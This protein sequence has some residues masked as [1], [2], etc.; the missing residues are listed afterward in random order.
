M[1]RM[2]NGGGVSKIQQQRSIEVV[3]AVLQAP[4]KNK[5]CFLAERSIHSF[6]LLAVSPFHRTPRGNNFGVS[7]DLSRIYALSAGDFTVRRIFFLEFSFFTCFFLLSGILRSLA[8]SLSLEMSVRSVCWPVFSP[9]LSE[10]Y[11][12]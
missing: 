1:C 12:Q 10:I 7:S 8:F 5:N 11:V 4:L 6:L 9:S 3:L 2:Y